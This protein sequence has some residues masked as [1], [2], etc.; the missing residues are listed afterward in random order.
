MHNEHGMKQS[1]TVRPVGPLDVGVLIRAHES[2]LRRR[3]SWLHGRGREV[4]EW[5]MR[6]GVPGSC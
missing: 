6:M 2:S 3:L 5:L 1:Y 4:D